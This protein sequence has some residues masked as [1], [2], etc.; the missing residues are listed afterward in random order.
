MT[1]CLEFQRGIPKEALKKREKEIEKKK[2][3]QYN[4]KPAE[5]ENAWIDKQ[6]EMVKLTY[7]LVQ[8]IF[9]EDKDCEDLRQK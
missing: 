5:F 6:L 8:R 7:N 1:F 2:Q 3:Y 9:E 4:Y